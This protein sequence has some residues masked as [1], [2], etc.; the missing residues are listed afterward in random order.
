M[1]INWYETC[2]MYYNDGNYTSDD[3]K[4]FVAKNK[5]TAEQYKQIC[6][7]DYVPDPV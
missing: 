6:G 5:I 2:L 1:A 4:V 7:L 3:L